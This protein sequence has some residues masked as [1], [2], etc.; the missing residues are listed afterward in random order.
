MYKD[1]ETTDNCNTKLN[2]HKIR[3][4]KIILSPPPL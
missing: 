2:C 4:K 1:K 3:K